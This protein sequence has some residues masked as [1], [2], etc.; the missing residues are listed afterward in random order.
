MTR[1]EDLK[2]SMRYKMTT[3]NIPGYTQ[4]MLRDISISLAKIADLLELMLG[5]AREEMEG[6][7]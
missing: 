5:A 2:D 7:R 6:L 1:M 4:E 3:T